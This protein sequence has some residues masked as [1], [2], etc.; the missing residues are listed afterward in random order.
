VNRIVLGERGV[1]AGLVVLALPQLAIGVWALVSP[2]GWYEG[3]P[4][5]GR[6]WLPLYDGSFDQHLAIDVGSSF[7]AIGVVLL[8]AAIW[9]Q[10]RLVIV[11]AVAYL[12]YQVPHAVFHFGADDALSSGDQV[13]NGIGLAL[14]LLLALGILVAGIRPRDAVQVGPRGRGGA[15][16]GADGASPADGGVGRLG[17]PPRGLL[18]RGMRS[19]MRRR[20]GSE[21]A[22]FDA[23]LHHR[24]LLYGYSAFETST[25]RSHRVDERLKL[26]AEMKAAAVVGCE[27]CMDFGSKL[28]RDAGVPDRQLR[29]LPLYRESDAFDELER[30]VIDYAAAMSRTPSEVDA[31][32]VER[33]RER[34]DD[35]QLVELTNVIAIENFRAR[36]NHALG[37]EPQGFSEGAACVVPELAGD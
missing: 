9:M 7:L 18:A 22:P 12:V 15:V 8:A 17:P 24:R 5:S 10:R 28:S 3:F 23:Y 35:A 25:E 6:H 32:L 16:G 14:A 20:F 1:R 31:G 13:A 29:E 36:F 34:F 33:L 11:A 21:L 2:R 26:L 30:L 4:G 37:F 27:W 19:Y